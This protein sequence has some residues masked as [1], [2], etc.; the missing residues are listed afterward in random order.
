[1]RESVTWPRDMHL[2]QWRIAC[3]VELAS[4][5]GKVWCSR[6][7][8][9]HME[10]VTAPVLPGMPALV[11]AAPYIR[12]LGWEN[13][14]TPFE[15]LSSSV[16]ATLNVMSVPF[17]SAETMTQGPSVFVAQ[18]PQPEVCEAGGGELRVT[19]Q[20]VPSEQQPG[21]SSVMLRR[22]Q[23]GH[24]RFRAFYTAFRLE[25]AGRVGM[26][27]VKQLSAYS[28]MLPKRVAPPLQ[29][30]SA[31]GCAGWQTLART[32]PSSAGTGASYLTAGL[33]LSAT[34]ATSDVLAEPAESPSAP[35]RRLE[36][37]QLQLWGSLR[38]T[39]QQPPSQP[40][41][42]WSRAE[43]LSSDA[44]R[45][46]APPPFSRSSSG[47]LPSLPTWGRTGP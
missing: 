23:G 25:F 1:M 7:G 26:P 36:Q 24:W 12:C 47:I 44:E 46:P 34:P 16:V 35:F 41:L 29:A 11:P 19:I 40:P 28:P 22:T 13:L 43:P 6:S 4:G 30:L 20:V 31:A 21:K 27:N 17:S 45:Q 9:Q 8:G 32:P 15:K 10:A 18:P 37:Q 14:D 33:H 5:R 42:L 3:S 39:E 2:S 38:D